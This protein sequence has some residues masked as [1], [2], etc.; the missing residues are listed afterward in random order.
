LSENPELTGDL[1]LFE[2]VEVK[3]LGSTDGMVDCVGSV[4]VGIT[5]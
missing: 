5:A 3:G 2:L 1:R 4:V